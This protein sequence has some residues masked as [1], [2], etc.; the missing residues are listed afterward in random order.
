M[1]SDRRF[2]PPAVPGF[3]ALSVPEQTL[4]ALLDASEGDQLLPLPQTS[5][6]LEQTLAVAAESWAL[7]RQRSPRI[8]CLTG[9][10]T[11]GSWRNAWREQCSL[12]VDVVV[13]K[14]L[15]RPRLPVVVSSMQELVM[16]TNGE[17]LSQERFDLIVFDGGYSREQFSP[18][19]LE[20]L[21]R[22]QANAGCVWRVVH[23]NRLETELFEL[24]LAGEFCRAQAARDGIVVAPRAKAGKPLSRPS[25]LAAIAGLGAQVRERAA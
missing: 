20:R 3:A 5:L 6:R 24:G 22:L 12:P 15:D 19:A 4:V 10:Q 13:A 7:A 14:I 8:L 1:S 18:L 25:G 2:I 21:G 16:S 17:Q 9:F 11:V 23:P